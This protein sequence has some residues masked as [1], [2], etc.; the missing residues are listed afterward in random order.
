MTASSDRSSAVTAELG[1]SIRARATQAVDRR[2]LSLHDEVAL[3]RKHGVSRW[4][5]QRAAVDVEVLPLRYQ[6]NFGTLGWSGQLRLL[7]S[8]ALV[9]GAGGLGGYLVE[10]LARMGVGRI[11]V[12]DGDTFAEHNLN[13][14]LYAT[15]ADLGRPKATV[16]AERGV[17]VNGGVEVVAHDRFLDE[18]NADDLVGDVDV[19]LDGLDSIP[20]RLLLQEAA[21]RHQVPLVHGAI[22]GFYAQVMTILPGDLGLFRF[23]RRG[24]GPTRGIEVELGNPAQTPM[25]CAALEVGEAIKAL[26]GIGT[27]LRDRLLTIDARDGYTDVQEL[28]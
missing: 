8:R 10:G 20:T 11:D 1:E 28:G 7:E 5:V 4:A 23:Y 14:Q 19:V 22:A 25:L 9:V 17:L 15:E 16:A 21:A 24:D 13:R 3:A 18:S 6:R 2:V 12:V 26:T 27:L